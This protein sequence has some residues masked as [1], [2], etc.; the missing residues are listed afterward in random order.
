MVARSTGPAE[1]GAR[2]LGNRSILADASRPEVVRVINEMIKSRDFWMPFAPAILESRAADYLVNPKGL[3]AP[4]MVLSF[5][6]TPAAQDLLA[7]MHPYDLTL[8]P[9]VIPESWNPGFHRLMCGFER[10]TGR[11]GMLNTSF[12]LHGL[13][14]VNTPD[15]ALDVLEASGLKHLALGGWLIT[16]R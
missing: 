8:R 2:A 4:Y 6:S 5:D 11:G 10:L 12:N 3:A 16:K 14:I 1:F 15:D 7:A 13:P 9:A